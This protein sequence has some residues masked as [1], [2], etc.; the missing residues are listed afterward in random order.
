MPTPT[1]SDARLAGGG[2]PLGVCS[3]ILMLP[4][5]MA[6]IWEGRSAV[7]LAPRTA[8][9]LAT[10]PVRL[11]GILRAGFPAIVRVSYRR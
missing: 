5:A 4:E 1:G 9:Y 7:L 2:F 10:R 6:Y 3:C 8:A 11:R